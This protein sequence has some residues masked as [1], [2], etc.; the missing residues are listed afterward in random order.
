MAS[1]QKEEEPCFDCIEYV[2]NGPE[3]IPISVYPPC[4]IPDNYLPKY[5]DGSVKDGDTIV[6]CK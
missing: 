4:T 2:V 5:P 6:L 1:C 3:L